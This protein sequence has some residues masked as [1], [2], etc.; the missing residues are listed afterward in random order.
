MKRRLIGEQ[1]AGESMLT[2]SVKNNR[3]DQIMSDY[4]EDIKRFILSYVKDP[5]V[6]NDLVQEVFLKVYSS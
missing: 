3:F 1:M 2:D 5:Q 4:G 6:T